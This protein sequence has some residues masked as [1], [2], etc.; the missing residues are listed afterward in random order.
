MIIPKTYFYGILHIGQLDTPPMQE[1]LDLYMKR[2]IKEFLIRWLGKELADEYLQKY[3]GDLKSL[4]EILVDR[5][6]MITPIAHYV[7]FMYVK[8]TYHLHQGVGV[9]APKAENAEKVSP[10]EKMVWA[11]NE[12][13]DM[14]CDKHKEIR[15][16]N[17][18]YKYQDST[19]IC[20]GCGCG[21]TAP[22]KK[23][24][25]FGI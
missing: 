25:R 16:L 24:N 12:M 11:W 14:I 19:N 13:V 2:Y 8:N 22:F 10:E 15:K 21:Y 20:G 17:L 6:L 1:A 23:I 5:E 3:D 4:D 7:Y 18:N 9:V